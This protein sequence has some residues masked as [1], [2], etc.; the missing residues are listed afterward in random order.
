MRLSTGRRAPRFMPSVRRCAPST[1]FARAEI[2][3]CLQQHS[4]NT[5]A[6]LSGSSEAGIHWLIER[7]FSRD[8]EWPFPSPV[9]RD[10]GVYFAETRQRLTRP[11][12]R[13]VR[14]SK[15]RMLCEDEQ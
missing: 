9:H 12:R 6:R 7:E 15:W 10:V 14:P 13:K 4:I 3:A 8:E 11:L 2:S 1:F 5:R